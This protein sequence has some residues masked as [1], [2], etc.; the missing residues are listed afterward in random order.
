MASEGIDITCH[1]FFKTYHSF[2]D[3]C[4]YYVLKNVEVF[5][6]EKERVNSNS[7]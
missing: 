3:I 5:W 2:I 4:K 6:N 1:A 7:E